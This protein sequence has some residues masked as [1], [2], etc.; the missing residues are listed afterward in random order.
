MLQPYPHQQDGLE[1]LDD[2]RRRGKT[3]ALVVMASGLG[4]TVTAALDAKRWLERHGGRMLYLCHQ[5][6]I[7]AQARATFE[8]VLGGSYSYG[9]FHGLEKTRRRVDCLFASFQTMHGARERFQLGEFSYVV[10]DESH[11]GTA[12]TYRPTIEYFKSG[13][14]LGI[15]ATPDRTDLQSIREIYGE[16]VFSLPLEDAL[17][18]GLLTSVN[19]RLMEDEIQNREVLDTPLGELSIELLNKKLFIPKRDE[20]IAGVIQKWMARV[21]NPRVMVFCP[22]VAHCDK[23]AAHLPGAV[24]IHYRLSDRAQRERLAAFRSGKADIVLTVDKFNEGI[25]VPEVNVIVFLRSTAS[26][27]LYFQQLGRGL[28]KA[29]GKDQV[30]VLDFVANCER[31]QTVI[32]LWRAVEAK[33]QGPRGQPQEAMTVNIRVGEIEFTDK[34][35]QILEVIDGI[36]EGYGKEV[37]IKQL[38]QLYDELGYTPLQKDIERASK[39]GKCP[40]PLVFARAFGSCGAALVAAGIPYRQ[41]K[42]SPEKCAEELQ[43]L[44]ASLSHPPTKKEVEEAA[45]KQLCADVWT[46]QRVFDVRTFWAV[47]EAAGLY[48]YTKPQLIRHIQTLAGELGRTPT[49][50]DIVKA[51]R[52]GKCPPYEAFQRML[53]RYTRPGKELLRKGIPGE[54]KRF[55]PKEFLRANSRGQ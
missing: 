38:R 42:N 43:A 31:L 22:S 45:R 49:R 51:S 41:P 28:R 20:E 9:Y 27:M 2:A 26:R 44:A 21:K 32:H 16:E 25:D 48:G 52:E 4:K 18:Q 40:R 5:N 12:Y 6:D 1:R 3:R 33:T 29:P 17:A 50:D 55:Y 14:L 7:L 47:L 24:P 11:H 34:T 36:R 10:V 8:V 53:S 13:F 35:R 46:L 54:G 23:L 19:Y 30:L 15:T 39:A 37:L